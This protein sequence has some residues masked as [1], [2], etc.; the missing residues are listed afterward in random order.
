MH[1]VICTHNVA[2][3]D[4]VDLATVDWPA[5]PR[6]GDQLSLIGKVFGNTKSFDPVWLVVDSIVWE[7]CEATD[8]PYD[9]TIRVLVRESIHEAPGFV[10]FCDC[11]EPMLLPA[12]AQA[13][14]DSSEVNPPYALA[15]LRAIEC[16]D[17]GRKI[18]Y[19]AVRV[20]IKAG[21]NAIRIYD[22]PACD[23]DPPKRDPWGD[24]DEVPL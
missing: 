18:E 8:A 6:V 19:E 23:P 3:G 9:A 5:V 22:P 10:P 15:R 2:D 1:I 20:A 7:A 4:F 16:Q 13:I 24:E 17:C 12:D 21:A 11:E 14:R